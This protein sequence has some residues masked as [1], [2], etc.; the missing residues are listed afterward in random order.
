MR[1]RIYY[2]FL[3]LVT[4]SLI[5]LTIAVSAVVYQRMITQ[6]KEAIRDKAILIASLFND[7]VDVTDYHFTDFFERSRGTARLTIIAPDGNILLDNKVDTRVMDNQYERTEFEQTVL[8]G[9]YETSRYSEILGATVYYYSILL[10]NGNVLRVS[11]TV[12]NISG[13]A[14]AILII[15]ILIMIVV[16]LFTNTVARRL[17]MYIIKPL[18]EISFEGGKPN[19]KANT[20]QPYEELIPFVLK[21]EK[22]KRKINEQISI[23]KHRADTIETITSNMREGL[24]LL[25]KDGIVLIANKRASEMLRDDDLLGKQI[26]HICRDIE[27]CRSVKLCLDGTSSMTELKRNLKSY[28]VYFSPVF[29]SNELGGGVILLCENNKQV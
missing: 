15:L 23:L 6:E 9:V 12:Y 19:E 27:F 2:S 28:S 17:T 16:I 13:V 26:T 1:K 11:Q 18:I 21:V 22:Q 7:G 14:S 10:D 29:T 3:G 24:I 8:Q 4:I 20:S 25:D 5:L